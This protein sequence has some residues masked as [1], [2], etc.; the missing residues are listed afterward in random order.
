MAEL[1]ANQTKNATYLE[2]AMKVSP[3]AHP[4]VQSTTVELKPRSVVHVCCARL[5][6]LRA[7]GAITAA[8]TAAKTTTVTK[9]TNGTTTTK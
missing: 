7:T 9:T 5:G 1:L 3:P 2:M 4:F 8:E 6:R